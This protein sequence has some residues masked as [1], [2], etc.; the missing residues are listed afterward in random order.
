LKNNAIT[1]PARGNTANPSNDTSAAAI[2]PSSRLK[3]CLR[4]T[5]DTHLMPRY[6][7]TV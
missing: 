2:S 5:S 4:E 7:E 6:F 1:L 3:R